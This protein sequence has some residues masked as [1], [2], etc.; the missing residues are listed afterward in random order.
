MALAIVLSVALIGQV[1]T[2]TC[3]APARP[4]VPNDPNAAQQYRELIRQDFEFYIQDIQA[5][6]RCLDEERA[7]AFVEAQE[8]SLEYGRFVRAADG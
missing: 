3:L 1:E 4:F 6:F 5:Y 7:R 8:V 2:E